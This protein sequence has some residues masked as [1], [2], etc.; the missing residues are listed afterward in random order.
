MSSKF[1]I[2]DF[3]GQALFGGLARAFPPTVASLVIVTGIFTV[4]WA[5]FWFL[6]RQKIFLKV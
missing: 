3:T 5:L 1:I 6:K 2:F 4:K